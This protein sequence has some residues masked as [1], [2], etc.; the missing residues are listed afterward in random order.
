[1][2]S[3]GERGACYRRGMDDAGT[4]CLD[5][6]LCCDGTLFGRVAIDDESMAAVIAHRLPLL[7]TTDG[8]KM[9]LPCQ[10]AEGVLC[11]LYLERPS[12]CRQ[13]TC[14]LRVA[15]AEERLSLDRARAVIEEVRR[16]RARTAPELPRGMPW[17]TVLARLRRAAPG[18]RMAL[19]R[20][21]E[22]LEAILEARFWS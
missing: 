9:P 2:P 20:D 3:A 1:M 14:E 10:G 17:W 11:S 12:R 19:R 4:L 22:A 21:L 18:V 16:I 6:G 7:D 5:C 15:A 13:Y 8:A